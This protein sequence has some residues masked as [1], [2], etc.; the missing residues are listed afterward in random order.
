MIKLILDITFISFLCCNLLRKLNISPLWA[1]QIHELVNL[2]THSSLNTHFRKY[3]GQKRILE[4]KLWYKCTF[5]PELSDQQTQTP[6]FLTATLQTTIVCAS[7]FLWHNG[8]ITL[9]SDDKFDKHTLCYAKYFIWRA[10]K[11]LSLR[12]GD[13]FD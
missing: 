3:F 4:R 1:L 8:V 12:R 10:I 5:F 2:T 6:D 7:Y 9:E 13:L 11:F